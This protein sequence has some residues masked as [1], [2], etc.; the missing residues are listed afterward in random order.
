[1]IRSLLAI[2]GPAHRREVGIYAV[3]LLAYGVLQGIAVTLLVP[4]LSSLLASEMEAVGYWLLSLLSVVVIACIARYQ[5]TVKGAAL[6]ILVLKTLHNR[7]GEHLSQLPLGW[8]SAE[9]VGRLSRSATGGTLMVTNVFAHL[10]P[11]T[12]SGVVTPLTV[13]VAMLWFDWRLGLTALLFVPLIYIGHR[14]SAQ[15]IGAM[16]TEVDAA[17]ARASSRVVEFARNQ[18]VLRSFGKNVSG[19]LPLEEA[20]AGQSGA[21]GSMLR[22]T[23]P[24]LFAGGFMVQL[25]FA[26]VIA[27]GVWL[28]LNQ[29]LPPIELVA[30]LALA[31]RFTGPL[32]ELAG[33]SGLL[34]MAGNDL[35]R[36]AAIFFEQSLPEPS[37][38][39]PFTEQ[40]GLVEFSNVNFS[41]EL[42]QP[43]LKDLSFR[44]SPGTTTAIVGASGSGKTTITRLL[45]R[46]FDTDQGQVKVGGVDVRQLRTEDLMRQI[47]IVMQDVY[48]FSDTLEANIR[49][50][51]PE[52]SQEALERVA[53]LAG[54]DEII[55]RLPQGWQTQ[56]GEGGAALSGGERQRVSIARA[57][58]KAAPI[59]VLDEATAA[60]DP[61]NEKYLNSSLQQLK[62]GSTVIV[63]AHQL[64]TVMNADQIIV[65]E[66][67]AVA[68]VGNHR[69]LLSQQG[70]YAHFWQQ[71]SQAT[72]WRLVESDMEVSL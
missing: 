48:L 40:G 61:R 68:E 72:G 26:A 31:A 13:G 58:L 3:W 21:A 28:T 55:E 69:K 64:S 11:P 51:H 43:V 5:Q 36:L 44:V 18:A 35:H 50:S 23:F 10:L 22:Q 12:V 45:L 39:Q 59:V 30:L 54:V 15:W 17:G 38:S 19:Y 25:A 57:L 46:F 33:R 53:K 34:R 4:L 29:Q 6:A 7:L 27:V 42:G 56:V 8:F 62:Q 1:M 9:K 67:G 66:E 2:L 37:R 70:L 65:L 49:L 52:A 24:R 63:I 60:L 14:W 41:Y 71:R 16:E 47:S 32:A 20:I